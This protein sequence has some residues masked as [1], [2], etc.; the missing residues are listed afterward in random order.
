MKHLKE[1]RIWEQKNV[2]TQEQEEFLNN[3]TSGTWSVNPDGEVDVDGDFDCSSKG[4]ESLPVAFGVVSGSFWCSDNSLTSLEGAPREVGGDFW[5]H[6]NSLT[7][8]GGAPREVG[9]SF[10]CSNNQLTTLE[11]AP[12]E[13]GGHF[14]CSRN[15]LSSLG[16]APREVGGGFYCYGNLIGENTLKLIFEF[17]KGKPEMPYGAVLVSLQDKIPAGDWNRLDRSAM[18]KLSDK[19]QKGYKLLGGIGGL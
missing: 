7:S 17:M 2:L 14:W 9:V 12:R 3:C 11:G 16:G 18:D 8:L 13:V 6:G 19:T 10:D 1:Y 15:Q 4:L 5:C